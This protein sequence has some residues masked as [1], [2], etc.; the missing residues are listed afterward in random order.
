VG[1][2]LQRVT[3]TAMSRAGWSGYDAGWAQRARQWWLEVRHLA[4]L[5]A[6]PETRVTGLA[7]MAL[8]AGERPGGGPEAVELAQTA[9]AAAMTEGAPPSLLSLL[10]AR[11]AI[12][13][14][15]VGDHPAATS[16]IARARHWL[17]QGRRP[18]EPF[19]LSFYGPADL[20][21]HETRVGL[22]TRIGKAAETAARTAVHSVDATSF[23]R[24]HLLYTVRFG[25]LLTQL[26]QFDEA[27]SVTRSAVQGCTRCA[28]PAGS[29]PICAAP[30]TC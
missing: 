19:W 6:V 11:E 27:I 1:R 18:D 16:A 2:E 3:A 26:G 17:D 12:G 14:T 21:W 10:T 20:A 29:S 23:P 24:N 28:A 4:D 5:A 30:L 13:H 22:L 15:Q 8:Q 25:L 7:A 9:T